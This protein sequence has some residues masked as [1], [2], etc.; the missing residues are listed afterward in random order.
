MQT[1]ECDWCGGE[2]ERYGSQLNDT[3]FCDRDC[4]G[5]YRSA[6]VR[7]EEHPQ[8]E[9]AVVTYECE[10][11]GTE[12]EIPRAWDREG[13]ARFCSRACK[14]SAERL[15]RADVRFLMN[16]NGYILIKTGNE[17][18]RHHRLV[19]VAEHGYEAVVEKDHVHH[20]DGTPW[21]DFGLNLQPVTASEHA[22]IHSDG[23]LRD[24]FA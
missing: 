7:G 5:E 1:V 23:D 17:Q 14:A 3:N 9:G 21:L 15:E 4:Y 16:P 13:H 19:A 6:Y 2:I 11:C 18:V 20:V 10:V 22:R 12:K 24:P 8:Y